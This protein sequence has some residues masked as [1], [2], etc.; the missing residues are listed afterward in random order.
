MNN[1]EYVKNNLSKFD[2]FYEKVKKEGCDLLKQ[3]MDDSWYKKA[4]PLVQIPWRDSSKP[5]DLICYPYNWLGDGDCCDNAWELVNKSIPVLIEKTKKIKS[6]RSKVQSI[7]KGN[8][9]Q[10]LDTIFELFVLYKFSSLIVDTERKVKNGSGSNVDAVIKLNGRE[11][12][13][14][15][16]RINKNLDNPRN[17]AGSMG[18]DKM[19]E[20]VIRKLEDK[21]SKDTQ[22]ALA[23]CPTI[24]VICLPTRGA[25]QET[26]RWALESKMN[27]FPNLGVVISSDNY[28]FTGCKW[29]INTQA[30]YAFTDYEIEQ[31]K[32]VLW[33]TEP[34]RIGSNT[35]VNLK[36]TV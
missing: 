24:L 23:E 9:C 4:R 20:Q 1:E 30:N 12:L 2:S 14:E 8:F 17:R 18:V 35:A 3:F 10:T 31:L 32:K 13:L 25:I 11:V 16:S 22:L 7:K 6:L 34:V 26:T 27:L 21:S 36:K 19:I 29:Y 5:Y 33:Q 28:N 15:V